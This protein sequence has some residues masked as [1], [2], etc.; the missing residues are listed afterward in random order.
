MTPLT[1][2]DLR[3]TNFPFF[4]RHRRIANVDHVRFGIFGD[5]AAG[6]DDG[7]GFD[8]DA[9]EDGGAGADPSAV[10]DDNRFDYQAEG[11]VGPVVVAGAEVDPLGDAAVAADA[12]RREGVEP[13]PLPDPAMVALRPASNPARS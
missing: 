6:G 11:G 12:D 4:H 1:P 2:Y 8:G 13:G 9:G 7:V 5:D 10:F 3:F